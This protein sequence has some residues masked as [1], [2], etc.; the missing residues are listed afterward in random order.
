METGHGGNVGTPKEASVTHA[1]PSYEAEYLA[2][3]LNEGKGMYGTADLNSQVK[4]NVYLDKISGNYK[5]EAD[6]CLKK[7]FKD[8]LQGTHEENELNEAY[9]RHGEQTNYNVLLNGEAE[10]VPK[11]ELLNSINYQNDMNKPKR[12]YMYESDCLKNPDGTYRT[13]PGSIMANWRPTWWGKK[14]LTHLPGVR[15]FLRSEYEEGAKSEFDMNMLAEHGPQDLQQAWMYFKHWVKGREL[16]DADCITNSMNDVTISTHGNM[17]HHM[18]PSYR[19]PTEPI[20]DTTA[21]SG[22]EV[23]GATLGAGAAFAAG[24][25]VAAAGL[26]AAAGSAAAGFTTPPRVATPAQQVS[27]VPPSDAGSVPPSEASSIPLH[28]GVNDIPMEQDEEEDGLWFDNLK[29]ESEHT[30]NFSK[31]PQVAFP[32][33]RDERGGNRGTEQILKAIPY[34]ETDKERMI[35]QQLKTTKAGKQATV[36][37]IREARTRDNELEARMSR[38]TGKKKAGISV[39]EL[40]AKATGNQKGKYQTVVDDPVDPVQADWGKTFTMGIDDEAAEE[41]DRGKTGSKG[42][43]VGGGAHY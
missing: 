10:V 22:P 40:Q 24:T 31:M 5:K 20:V 4:Q 41:R 37:D 32:K 14:G 7:E 19:T 42:G 2:R 43:S 26:A 8:W 35:K 29:S 23:V 1:W 39:E 12:K 11:A 6:D 27:S 17:P 13:I 9:N 28:R 18:G 36:Q 21:G 34:P 16:T 25:G 38:L 30:V 3:R 15:G 33:T